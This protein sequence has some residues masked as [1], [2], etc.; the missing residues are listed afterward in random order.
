MWASI[1][2]GGAA[3]IAGAVLGA[4]GLKAAFLCFSALVGLTLLPTA[5]L[6]MEA[7]AGK[8]P[9]GADL[10]SRTRGGSDNAGPRLS[11]SSDKMG[12]KAS[13]CSSMGEET[14]GL[15]I[16]HVSCGSQPALMPAPGLRASEAGGQLDKASPRPA[17]ADNGWSI[18]SS[19]DKGLPM[20]SSL[21]L[22]GLLA[23]AL[24]AVA[25]GSPPPSLQR[26]LLGPADDASPAPPRATCGTCG[27]SSLEIAAAQPARCGTGGGPAA[28]EAC[29][30]E[31]SVWQGVR[32]LLR[33]V[34]VLVFLLLALLMGIGNGAIG[35]GRSRA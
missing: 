5:L 6:P 3:P 26:P 19:L 7:L 11:V 32:G 20:H 17:L 18:G 28:G 1:G 10:D 21:A 23:D 8:G 16:V 30:A 12:G 14:G 29:A 31:A 15:L 35:C 22:G 13:S 9:P 25:A 33:D 27:S 2:W 34:H 24:D 4:Y